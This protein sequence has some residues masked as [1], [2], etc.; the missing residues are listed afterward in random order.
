MCDS[1]AENGWGSALLV[2][3]SF[4]V[5]IGTLGARGGVPEWHLKTRTWKRF[6]L[7]QDGLERGNISPNGGR[8][9]SVEIMCIKAVN[10]SQ[11]G[12]DPQAAWPS[13]SHPKDGRHCEIL[14]HSRIIEGSAM[15][16]LKI[17]LDT[18][19]KFE[20]PQN[21]NGKNVRSFKMME[22]ATTN[23]DEKNDWCFLYCDGFVGYSFK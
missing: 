12:R 10:Q 18:M 5:H 19:R 11:G 16:P 23:K 3:L 8:V 1:C 21:N 9:I 7:P 17:K 14:V 13:R 4:G 20:N 6:P 15:C 2:G 22:P